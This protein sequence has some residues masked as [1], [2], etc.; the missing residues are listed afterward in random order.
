MSAAQS[1]LTGEVTVV[2]QALEPAVQDHHPA[3]VLAMVGKEE[4]RGAVAERVMVPS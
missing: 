4:P 1:M 2:A 3:E